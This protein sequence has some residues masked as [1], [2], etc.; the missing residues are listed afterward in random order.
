MLF[1]GFVIPSALIASSP[2][3]FS[4]FENF[5]SPFSIFYYTFIQVLGILFWL[6]CIYKLFPQ[7]IQKYFAFFSV[8][9]IPVMLINA[10]IFKGNYGDISNALLFEDSSLLKHT[11]PYFLLNIFIRIFAFSLANTPS[12]PVPNLKPL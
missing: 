6:I 11:L 1:I 8:I 5:T 12:F 4:N 2:Q 7:N 3:E 9:I 10:Y